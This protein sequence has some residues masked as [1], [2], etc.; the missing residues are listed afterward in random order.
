MTGASR[1][2]QSYTISDKE[3]SNNDAT[4]LDD[5]DSGGSTSRSKTT[6]CFQMR[7]TFAMFQLSTL[8]TVHLDLLCQE[9]HLTLREGAR[10]VAETLREGARKV[11]ET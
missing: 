3:S 7:M 4:A 9:V 2:Q 8:R 11:A 5:S 1:Q 6:S 10:K